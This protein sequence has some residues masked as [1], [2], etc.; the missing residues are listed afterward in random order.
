MCFKSYKWEGSW[1]LGDIDL[2]CKSLNPHLTDAKQTSIQEH[3]GW[4]VMDTQGKKVLVGIP[5]AFKAE[6]KL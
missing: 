1:I 3:N 2:S 5:F 6:S 4:L